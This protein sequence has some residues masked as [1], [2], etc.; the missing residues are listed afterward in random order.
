[1]P[2]YSGQ[3]RQLTLLPQR[4][5]WNRVK[6]KFDG[7]WAS[8]FVILYPINLFLCCLQYKVGDAA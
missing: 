3:G 4:D 7:F 5:A 1:M 8:C 2:W 6:N